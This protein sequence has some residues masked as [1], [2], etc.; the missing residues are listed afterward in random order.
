MQQEIKAL[1]NDSQTNND[2][3]K[4]K[5]LKDKKEQLKNLEKE[6]N[7]TTDNNNLLVLFSVSGVILLI[8][9]TFLALTVRKRRKK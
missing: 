1:E 2:S 6:K 5:E 8:G 9:G 4:Q 7:N 3:E